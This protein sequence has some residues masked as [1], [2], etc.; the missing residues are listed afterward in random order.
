[1]DLQEHISVGLGNS[2]LYWH[3]G[4]KDYEFPGTYIIHLFAAK[5][6]YCL[7]C[8]KGFSV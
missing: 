1:M 7:I 4:R 5:L 8:L 6:W 3:V 2:E